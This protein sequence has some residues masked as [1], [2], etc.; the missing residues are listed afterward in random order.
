MDVRI[1]KEIMKQASNISLTLFF[2]LAIY[3]FLSKNVILLSIG[4]FCLVLYFYFEDKIF[5]LIKES[6]KD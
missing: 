2:C 6:F 5:C 1:K 3:S 4:V